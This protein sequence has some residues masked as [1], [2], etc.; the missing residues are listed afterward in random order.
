MFVRLS[1]SVLAFMMAI[2]PVVPAYVLAE[3]DLGG[4]P[5]D[6]TEEE[7]TEPPKEDDAESETESDEDESKREESG[8]APADEEKD[9]LGDTEEADIEESEVVSDEDVGTDDGS[10]S[11]ARP[12]IANAEETGEGDTVSAAGTI[13]DGGSG[14][15]AVSDPISRREDMSEYSDRHDVSDRTVGAA[16]ERADDGSSTG[17][18][19]TD[20][21]DV[22]V[23]VSASSDTGDNAVSDTG[24]DVTLGT[25]DADAVA[26]A[27]NDVNTTVVGTVD[28]S[29]T[30]LDG[31]TEGDLDLF[32][33]FLDVLAE[34]E[35]DR[36]LSDPNV[37]MPVGNGNV[38]EVTNEAF[39]SAG[40][41][42]NAIADAEGDAAID[43]GD[44]SAL[45]AVVNLVN[46][47]LIGSG[48]F[49][50]IDNFGE[51]TG[52]IILPGIGILSGLGT[53]GPVTVENGNEAVITDTLSASA[54]TG[55]N[56]VSD[57]D[58]DAVI[59]TGDAVAVA[60][61]R[62]V[63]NLNLVG[64]SWLY[65]L[66]NNFGTW[67]GQVI[68][69]DEVIADSSVFSYGLGSSDEASCEDGCGALPVVSN[70]NRAVITNTVSASADTGG[71]TITGAEGDAT[72]GT[73]DASAVAGIFNLVNVNIVGS[74]WFFGVFNNFGTWRGNI[75]FAYPDLAVAID[76]GRD[77][78]LSGDPLTY[79]VTVE[80]RGLATA[81]GVRLDTDFPEG[82][83]GI[84]D[85]PTTMLPGDSFVF[86][87]S[88]TVGDLP[89][90]TI[91]SASASVKSGTVEKHPENDT[92]SDST[93]VDAVHAVATGWDFF[94]GDSDSDDYDASLR[95]TR[96]AGSG[97]TLSGGGSVVSRI[98]V[99]NDGRGTVSDIVV[100]DVISDPDGGGL[101]TLLFTV[102]DLDPGE[103][104]V[105][106]YEILVPTGSAPGTYLATAIAKG[107]DTESDRSLGGFTVLAVPVAFA[108][109]LPDG[110]VTED[111]DTFP[112]ATA[113]A[114]PRTLG[115]SDAVGRSLPIWMLLF[116]G[117]AYHLAVNWSLF[118]NRKRFSYETEN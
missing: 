12:D 94:G 113:Y 60:D 96:D 89:A 98:T 109:E 112:V 54:D 99:R 83:S 39:A 102:G 68:D 78:A 100:E 10:G 114:N 48:L 51:F 86:E 61:S 111:S 53:S 72:I 69:G 84:P 58:G 44:A 14:P 24:D 32:G 70:D 93:T 65:F 2:F 47:N 73:G 97:T 34:T 62:T 77:S 9:R 104:A 22:T 106:D 26:V 37:V 90:G 20:D 88:G 41:G 11:G 64:D 101:G 25:G 43:T 4:P 31:T 35:D 5:T 110:P 75:V 1:A 28:R 79:R 16:V 21:A 59:G 38:A 85:V 116:S 117:V 105:I 49:A 45:A 74:G 3:S 80:N 81:E 92:A 115:V 42:D 56:A 66:F 30:D 57:T 67:I 71:N 13:E 91:L 27:V 36:L 17:I 55:G 29:V 107:D 50:V 82:W 76:D 6:E 52:D 95:L 23:A 103:G 33:D 19:N 18:M 15:E 8:E 108:G 118:P 7:K 40:T 46:L 87:V 63:A